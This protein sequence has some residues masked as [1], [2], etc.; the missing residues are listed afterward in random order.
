[1]TYLARLPLASSGRG[2]GTEL[3]A[4]LQAALTSVTEAASTTRP[5]A[6]GGT[7]GVTVEG[8]VRLAVTAGAGVTKGST[9]CHLKMTMNL[10]KNGG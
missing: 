7:D 3:T 6:Q 10:H 1:M 2:G 5:A 8:G 4:D 9:N